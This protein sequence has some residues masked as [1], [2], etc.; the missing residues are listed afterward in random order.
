MIQIEFDN[1]FRSKQRSIILIRSSN[2]GS[3]QSTR[4]RSS[5]YVKV[6]RYPRLWTVQ[7]LNPTIHLPKL[8]TRLD[9]LSKLSVY[10]HKCIRT[11]KLKRLI[12]DPFTST[13]VVNGFLI[14]LPEVF[15]QEIWV[16]C[17][18]WSLL[19]P[20]RRCLTL[21]SSSP[22]QSLLPYFLSLPTSICCFFFFSDISL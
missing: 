22:F 15:V 11:V 5:N 19:C 2:H 9:W 1:I 20:R 12:N 3:H 21:L 6:I 13:S 8:D 18:E 10:K 17:P 14:C 4:T 16:Q 7:I